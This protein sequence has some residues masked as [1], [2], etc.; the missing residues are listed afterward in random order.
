VRPHSAYTGA[1][2]SSSTA[3]SPT[4][5]TIAEVARA[6]SVPVIGSGDVFSAE[7][8]RSMLERTGVDAVMVARGAQGNPWIFREA[9]GLLDR[10][11]TL[12]PPTP[13]SAWTW[14]ANTPMRWWPSRVR[15][16]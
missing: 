9:R 6:V 1:P 10:G 8:A 7:D 15:T 14:R 5:D 11:E 13:S 3:V 16:P 2:G 12:P 4:G